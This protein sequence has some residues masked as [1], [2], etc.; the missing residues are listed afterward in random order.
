[1]RK[2]NYP[3]IVS[4]YDGTLLRSDDRVSEETKEKIHEYIAAGGKFAICSGRLL[5]SVLKKAKELGLK[6]LV[7]AYQ[8]AVIADIES[9]EVLSEGYIPAEKAALICRKCEALGLHTHIYEIENYY[10]NMAGDKLKYYEKLCGVKGI[11][12]DRQPL[13]EFLLEKNMRVQKILVLVDENEKE[14]TYQA[15]N[16]AFGQ[17]FY[18]TYSAAFLVELT[19]KACSKATAV[20]FLA[21]YYGVPVERTVAVGDHFNDLPMIARAGLGIAVANADE[22]LKAEADVVLEASNDENAIGKIIERYGFTE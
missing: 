17:E 13:S 14:S 1:M 18:V 11:L 20:E 7:G 10:T 8:G 19:N 9:G 4:D 21:N 3:L 15:L 12:V 2:I 22:K 5:E 6:G 16:E